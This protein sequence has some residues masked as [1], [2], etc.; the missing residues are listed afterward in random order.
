MAVNKMIDG[1][2]ITGSG[3]SYCANGINKKLEEIK[4]YHPDSIKT[5]YS[6]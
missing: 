6:C 3:E 4:K 1:W 5:Y 2:T